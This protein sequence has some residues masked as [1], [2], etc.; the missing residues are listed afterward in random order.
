MLHKVSLFIR[1]VRNINE[2]IFKLYQKP[3]RAIII[4]QSE[5]TINPLEKLTN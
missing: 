4:T 5:L 1:V 2:I 3:Y